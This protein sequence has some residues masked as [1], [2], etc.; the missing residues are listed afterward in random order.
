MVDNL[1]ITYDAYICICGM[2]VEHLLQTASTTTLTPLPATM[3]ITIILNVGGTE[4]HTT[5]ETLSRADPPSM[6]AWIAIN[7]V[8]TVRDEHPSIRSMNDM[9]RSTP[10]STSTPSASVA[11]A[12]L[13]N[14]LAALSLGAPATIPATRINTTRTYHIDRNPKH[15]TYV[16]DYLRSD[17]LCMCVCMCV[18]C[19][20]SVCLHLCV[21]MCVCV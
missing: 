12:N 4:F 2:I 16:L 11:A 10:I 17:I 14:T 7:A 1:V 6:L 20:C 19:V 18:C 15:F 8:Q 13:S 9:N 5:P 3:G 21:C